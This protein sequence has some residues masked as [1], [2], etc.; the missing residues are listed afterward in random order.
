MLICQV[1]SYQGV[2]Q[3]AHG[4]IASSLVCCILKGRA[5]LSCTYRDRCDLRNRHR[6]D[7]RTRRRGQGMRLIQTPI[8]HCPWWRAGILAARFRFRFSPTRFG[9]VVS[10]PFLD[11]VF[12]W[13]F[14]ESLFGNSGSLL[15]LAGPC[16]VGKVRG[17]R[18]GKWQHSLRLFPSVG[19]GDTLI[20]TQICTQRCGSHSFGVTKGG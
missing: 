19:S 2:L 13:A 1:R 14:M 4:P 12:I 9:G 11:Y 15:I 3:Q 20:C 17:M 5:C 18:Q 8:E 16:M 7:G 10:D 6:S